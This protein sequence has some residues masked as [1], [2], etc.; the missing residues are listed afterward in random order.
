MA[1]FLPALWLVLNG[2]LSVQTALIRFIAALLVSWVAAR[3]V[4]AT[5][6]SHSRSASMADAVGGK[7]AAP[8]ANPAGAAGLPNENTPL[9]D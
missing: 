9:V 4:L 1:I 2:N 3:I 6:N 8:S 7:P 5:V